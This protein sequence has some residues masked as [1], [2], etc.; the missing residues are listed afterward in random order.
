ML[1]G[2]QSLK[3]EDLTYT[4]VGLEI[5]IMGV[6]IVLFLGGASKPSKTGLQLKPEK[7]TFRNKEKK[8]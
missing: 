2:F 6:A 1:G 8:N 4:I 3:G 5:R 7:G